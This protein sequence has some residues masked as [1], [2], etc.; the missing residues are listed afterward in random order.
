MGLDHSILFLTKL[1]LPAVVESRMSL[2]LLMK[3]LA[4]FSSF[5]D[6]FQM[7]RRV[8]IILLEAALI[9]WCSFDLQFAT[10]VTGLQIPM[11]SPTLTVIFS[12]HTLVTLTEMVCFVF[13][14]AGARPI[15]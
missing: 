1:V 13:T 4:D 6:K 9:S 8:V 15:C 3:F 7:T 14:R 2:S 10:H 11:T 12:G 5:A